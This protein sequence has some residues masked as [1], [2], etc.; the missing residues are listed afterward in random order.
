MSTKIKNIDVLIPQLIQTKID[1][2]E[3][4]ILGTQ[5]RDTKGRIVCNLDSL[6]LGQDKY[7]SP[8]VFQVFNGCTFI[9]STTISSR[10]YEDLLESQ[11]TLNNLD[12]KVD[13]ILDNQTNSL[14]SA[15]S[16][17]D[18]HFSSLMEGSSL[19]SKEIT[20]ST[21]VK[22]ACLLATNIESYLKEFRDSTIVFHNSTS[23][24]G[25][26]YLNYINRDKYK[27]KIFKRKTSR[28]CK[29]QANFFVYS[30]LKILNNI[31]LLSISYDKKVFA[32][33]QDNLDA[34]ENSLKNLLNFLIKGLGDE[35][36]IYDMCYS[37]RGY[38]GKY[39]PIDIERVIKYDKFT[40]VHELF[41]R[42]FPKNIELE[43]D[44]NRVKSIYDITDLLEE[45]EN[46]R[47]RFFQFK[48]LELSELSEVA[49]IKREIFKVK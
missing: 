33:Y 47:S 31:N 1:E 34:L 42:N 15:I 44:E 7:F 14:I 13:R 19:T 20:F 23:Y 40:N 24:K 25:E 10:L 3:Y 16:V 32:R 41:L 12:S 26:K 28:F 48:N 6:D 22:A 37:T 49:D 21:G 29:Y 45:I 11:T 43:Y 9:S 17:S 18:E 27:P 39:Y 4:Q 35:G 46:L 36:D 30:F 5:V 2:G 8:H 38:N